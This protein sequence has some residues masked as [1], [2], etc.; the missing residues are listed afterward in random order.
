L[1]GE[2]LRFGLVKVEGLD[3][4]VFVHQSGVKGASLLQE[5]QEVELSMG[6]SP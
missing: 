3:D 2:K 4:F 6:N 1:R 5:G